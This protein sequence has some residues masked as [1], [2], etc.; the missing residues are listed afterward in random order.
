MGKAGKA[1]KQV[2]EQYEITQN[3]LAVAMGISRSNIHRWV[4]EVGDPA[5]DSIIEIRNALQQID[6]NAAETFTQL[7]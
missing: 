3:Q 7:Y 6:P 2:L 5:G 4:Y 1:L